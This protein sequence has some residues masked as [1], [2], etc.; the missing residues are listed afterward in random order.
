MWELKGLE[1]SDCRLDVESEAIKYLLEA[2]FEMRDNDS[3][4]A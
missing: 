2:R 4:I 3:M 1:V